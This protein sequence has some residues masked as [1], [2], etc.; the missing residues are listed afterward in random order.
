MPGGPLLKTQGHRLHYWG[1]ANLVFAGKGASQAGPGVL[2]L[3]AH[4]SA[5][6]GVSSL[7]DVVRDT[8]LQVAAQIGFRQP[9][10]GIWLPDGSVHEYTSSNGQT[11]TLVLAPE[12]GAD[13]AQAPGIKP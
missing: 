1:G 6:C 12:D 3:T 8:P 10:I 5:V 11:L 9:Y 4:D 2:A 13:L 7:P